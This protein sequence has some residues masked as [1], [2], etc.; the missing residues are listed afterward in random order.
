MLWHTNYFNTM[1]LMFRTLYP[2][3][4][5]DTLIRKTDISPALALLSS[6]KVKLPRKTNQV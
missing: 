4:R 3:Y 2:H 1:V 5:V 6:S